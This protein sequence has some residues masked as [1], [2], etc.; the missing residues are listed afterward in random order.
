MF[1]GSMDDG[2]KATD[3]VEELIN[4]FK[5]EK[6]EGIIL[7]LRRMEGYLSEAVNLTGLFISRGSSCTS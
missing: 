3:D 2:P 5:Q 7:D 1:Y 6:V 4:K